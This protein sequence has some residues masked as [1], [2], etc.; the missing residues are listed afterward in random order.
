LLTFGYTQTPIFDGYIFANP[1]D[2]LETNKN[3][4]EKIE[5]KL[6]R[7]RSN[8]AEERSKISK[9][10]LENFSKGNSTEDVFDFLKTIEQEQNQDFN[11][12]ELET[13]KLET[14]KK[15][16]INEKKSLNKSK[17]KNKNK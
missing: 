7:A 6:V 4:S 8:S 3:V 16:P 11:T 13:T 9:E 15:T 12:M 2:K 1:Q 10:L 17:N 5:E 14:S